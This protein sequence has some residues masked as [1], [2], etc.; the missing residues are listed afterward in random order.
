MEADDKESK[1]V[2]WKWNRL[3]SN[4]IKEEE[5]KGMMS[6]KYKKELGKKIVGGETTNIFRNNRNKQNNRNRI[7]RK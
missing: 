7:F 6:W 2:F 1:T 4:I 5:R 3:Y